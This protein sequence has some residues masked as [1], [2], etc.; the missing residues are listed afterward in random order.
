MSE[1]SK[2]A[3]A[4]MKAKAHRMA[5]GSSG[6]VDASDYDMPTFSAEKK[7]GKRPLNPREYKRGG[8]VVE[9]MSGEAPSSKHAGKMAR[10]PTHGCRIGNKKG[11]WDDDAGASDRIA[12]AK[13]GRIGK[14]LGGDV[15]NALGMAFVPGAFLSA[16]NGGGKGEKALGDPGKPG[17][18]AKK[19]GGRV[20]RRDGGKTSKGKTS[21]G[22]T[23]IN[24]IIGG[25]RESAPPAP[26]PQPG[27][28]HPPGMFPPGMPPGAPP[29]MAAPPAPP[30]GAMAGMMPRK[31]GGRTFKKMEYGAGSGEGRLEKIGKTP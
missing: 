31:S 12:R 24:I 26:P 18:D 23:N 8:K 14:D 1:Q 20:A 27:P 22:K 13:G 21:K 29:P 28:I 10:H 11:N 25:G 3:R 2:S 19:N 16:L 7:L 5:E 4:A 9:H 17:A 30:P 6:N 15:G